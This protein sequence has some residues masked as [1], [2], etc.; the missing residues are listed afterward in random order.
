MNFWKYLLSLFILISPLQIYAQ[1]GIDSV[2]P[3]LNPFDELNN[4]YKKNNLN[5]TVYIQM[6]DS[7]ANLLLDKGVFYSVSAMAE[8]LKQYEKVAWSRE[9]YGKYRENYYLRLLNNAYMSDYLGA[10]MYYAEKYSRE[11]EKNGAPHPFVELSVKINIYALTQNDKEVITTY[12]KNRY[13]IEKLL[14]KLKRNPDKYYSEGTDVMGILGAAILAYS[15]QKDTQNIEKTYWLA[16]NIIKNMERSSLSTEKSKRKRKFY[17]LIFNYYRAFGYRNHEEALTVLNKMEQWVKNNDKEY[18]EY[19]S[20]LFEWK[21]Y[22]FLEMKQPDS[23][24]Y[25][26]DKYE[27]VTKFK[28]DKQVII[29]KYKSQLEL[30]KGN[31]DKAYSL[32]HEAF[33]ESLN[34]QKELSKELDHLIYAQTKAE[35]HRLAFEKSEAEKKERNTWIIAIS[36]LLVVVITGSI[37]LLWLKDRKLKRTIKD[38]NETANIQIALM[39]QLETRV[40]KEEQERISQNLHDDLAG[41]LAAI[42]NNMDLQIA[43]TEEVEKRERLKQLAVMVEGVFHNVRNKSHELFEMAQLPDEEILCQHILHL[44]Q[45]AFPEKY[46]KFNIEV[47][48][49]ALENTSLELRSE[50]LRVI[51][52]A[53]ANI[54]KH[55]KATQVDLLI[56]KEAGKIFV[57]IKDNGKGFRTLN[58][59]VQESTL[60][61]HS[62]RNRLNRFNAWFDINGSKNGVEI[63]ITIPEETA[64]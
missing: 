52:E 15:V 46:Y 17:S 9:E 43:E 36:L 50:L 32:L 42:K 38:L 60:G 19:T 12:E 3:K 28:L 23:A 30:L 41:T 13:H 61:V 14:E 35:H 37:I 54:V 11:S 2:E 56:Y 44:A 39:E 47:D 45:I 27:K 64:T 7:V 53:F 6:V 48:D 10:T 5:D 31:P 25:Y 18:I 49:Y 59:D 21:A 1:V 8:N 62:M 58:A 33:D 34:I 63:I 20:S 24:A 26:L 51:Q 4:L 55:A 57:V 22:Q 29:Y 40:R 16:S